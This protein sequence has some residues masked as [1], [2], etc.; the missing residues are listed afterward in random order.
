MSRAQKRSA[1]C[2]GCK[3]KQREIENLKKRIAELE[4]EIEENANNTNNDDSDSFDLQD[5]ITKRAVH[6]ESDDVSIER[7][8]EYMDLIDNCECD[9]TSISAIVGRYSVEIKAVMNPKSHEVELVG[10][11]SCP[12]FRHWCKHLVACG[13]SFAK[14]PSLFE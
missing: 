13:V 3:A 4:E 1:S 14:D 2:R 10:H 12:S 5:Y 9:D 6:N 8:E 7:S 11:C